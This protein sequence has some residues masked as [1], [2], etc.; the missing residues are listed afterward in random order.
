[1]NNNSNVHKVSKTVWVR[2]KKLPGNLPGDDEVGKIRK[3][4]SSLAEGGTL[5]GL[6]FE[7]EELY[8]P[9]LISMS[10]K[11]EYWEAKTKEYWD[12]ISKAVDTGIGLQLETGFVYK[13]KEGAERNACGDSHVYK[14]DVGKPIKLSEYVLWRY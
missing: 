4:G 1:M 11:S 3:I 12:N 7:E 9:Q 6:T 8:L 10:P 2:R 13:T 5:R 14:D